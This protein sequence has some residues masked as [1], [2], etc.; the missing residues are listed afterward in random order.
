MST[1]A[2]TP[3]AFDWRSPRARGQVPS[4]IVPN[5]PARGPAVQEV[6]PD[7]A[8]LVAQASAGSERAFSM[9]Y[10]R[11]ARYVAGVAYRL[12]GGDAELDDVV[13]ET[14]CDAH[15]ALASLNEPAGLRAWLAR[16]AVRRVHK[17]LAKRR[18]WRWMIGEAAQGA[19]LVSDPAQRQRVD[20]LYEALGTL[21]ADLRLP[22][23]LH[24]VEGETLPDVA[25]MCEVSLATA[26]RRIAEAAERLERK[27]QP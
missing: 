24:H 7:D 5:V 21:P 20:A 3:W 4:R 26:K 11:H 14:F 1:L 18:R 9:L 22:W 15:A 6:A 25:A 2:L 13:Q 23:T 17:R 8:A 16:I 12:L 10:R 19:P 27:L